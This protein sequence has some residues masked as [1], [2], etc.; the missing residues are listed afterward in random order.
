MIIGIT[1]SR[2]Y[3]N[4]CNVFFK[5]VISDHCNN[6]DLVQIILGGAW[7]GDTEALRAALNSRKNPNLKLTVVV[8]DTFQ[9][10]PKETHIFT[11][12][13][14]E[15]IELKNTGRDRYKIRNQ[16]IVD[17]C[18]HLIA[19]WN[20]DTASGTKQTINLAKKAG[21]TVEVW[22]LWK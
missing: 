6:P 4:E 15:V 3:N 1:A 17:H 18:D 9:A 19:F 10:Q 22:H 11:A 14:D 12:Q 2:S 13:A 20:G 8:P 7:G 21:K 5:K 16:Y